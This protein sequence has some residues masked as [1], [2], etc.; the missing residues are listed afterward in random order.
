[1]ITEND[2]NDQNTG[3]CRT[4]SRLSMTEK[5]IPCLS[6]RSSEHRCK[7]AKNE[8]V[9]ENT[10]MSFANGHH[11]P[12]PLYEMNKVYLESSDSISHLSA[13]YFLS[14]DQR[15]A[16]PRYKD[17]LDERASSADE[18]SMTCGVFS[19]RNDTFTLHSAQEQQTGDVQVDCDS[20][21]DDVS[22]D[23]ALVINANNTDDVDSCGS[24]ETDSSDKYKCRDDSAINCG[25]V[26]DND[27]NHNT[28]SK[29]EEDTE[30]RC[31]YDLR[32][33]QLTDVND[34]LPNMG[35]EVSAN[36]ARLTLLYV[37]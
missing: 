12:S 16:T 31:S 36:N 3:D 21:D 4:C 34:S 7:S 14:D 8:N 11:V 6:S 5:H 15:Y 24:V 30:E 9:S 32:L 13:R 23:I 2:I 17:L 26:N 20:E 27:L 22:S 1:M 33:S 28:V 10:A 18:R 29:N 37:F 35:S 19:H 25:N